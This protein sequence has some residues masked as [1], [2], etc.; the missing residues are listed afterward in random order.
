MIAVMK[1][2]EEISAWL[3]Q[4]DWYE[5]FCRQV[6]RNYKRRGAAVKVPND[7]CS[8]RFRNMTIQIAFNWTTSDE[9]RE[10]WAKVNEEFYNWCYEK[11]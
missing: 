5:S 6:E 9:G 11:D 1:T 4:H 7:I 2:A 8:G 3:Q 10:F